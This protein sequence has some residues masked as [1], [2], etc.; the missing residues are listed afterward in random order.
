MTH[1]QLSSLCRWGG[2]GRQT[3]RS[4]WSEGLHS[5]TAPLQGEV[6]DMLPFCSVSS[7]GLLSWKLFF[8]ERRRKI[9]LD[10]MWCFPVWGLK[11]EGDGFFRKTLLQREIFCISAVKAATFSGRNEAIDFSVSVQALCRNPFI[12]NKFFLYCCAH[13]SNLSHLNDGFVWQ[14]QHAH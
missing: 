11:G 9:L 13:F 14:H 10:Y 6:K 4:T 8:H 2:G 1:Q 3:L 12:I 5:S 7:S